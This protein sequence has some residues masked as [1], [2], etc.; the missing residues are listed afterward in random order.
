MALT[1]KQ[2]QFVEAKARGA[3]NTQAALKAGYSEA[4]APQA[5]SRLAKHPEVIAALAK[6]AERAKSKSKGSTKEKSG[7][8]PQASQPIVPPGSNV[9]ALSKLYEDPKAFLKAVMNDTVSDMKLR[10][11]AAKA[12]LPYEHARL[13][14]GGKKEQKNAAAKT[15]ASK[16][17]PAQPPKLVAA[18]GKKV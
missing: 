12:M 11:D 14:E 16:F 4:T 9:L 2:R 13:G 6:L 3:S 1:G 10:V 5:G 7:T 15:A 18:G 8:K 17:A